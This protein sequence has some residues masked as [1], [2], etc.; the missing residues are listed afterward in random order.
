M[1]CELLTGRT[2]QIRAQFAHAKHPLLGDSQYGKPQQN[3]KYQRSY[4]ALYAYKLVFRFKTDASVLNELNGKS[5]QV[6]NVPFVREFFF[7]GD[8]ER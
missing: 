5:W 1:E 4:Q 8:N 2:H 6:K 7:G 3:E